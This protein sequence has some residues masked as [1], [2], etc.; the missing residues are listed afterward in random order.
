MNH[1]VIL[2]TGPLVAAISQQDIYHQWTVDQLKQIRPPLLTCEAVISEACFLLRSHNRGVRPVF[3]WL[4]K[5]TIKLSF[6]LDEETE[7]IQQLMLKYAADV[8]S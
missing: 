3:E 6:H 7:T 5:G 8:F 2:D 4:Y 1:Q